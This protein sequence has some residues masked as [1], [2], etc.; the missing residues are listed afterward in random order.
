MH[1]WAIAKDGDRKSY[2]A[3]SL[4][5]T[6]MKGKDE[7]GDTA[8]EITV[9]SMDGR[10]GRVIGQPWSDDTIQADFGVGKID[11]RNDTSE[12]VFSTY[13]GG[14]HC[15]T[16]TKI[17]ELTKSGWVVLDLGPHDGDT[18]L[19]PADV[20]GTSTRAFVLYDDRFLY[21]FAS[22][23]DSY[24]P[25]QVFVIRDA[26][27]VDESA[28]G[29]FRAVYGKDL[30]ETEAGCRKHQNGACAGFV[31]DATRLGRFD[32]AWATMLQNYNKTD[33]WQLPTDCDVE[34][35][36]TGECPKG[37]EHKFGNYPDALRAFLKRNGYIAEGGR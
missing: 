11:P 10:V 7:D 12:V 30:K 19:F 9:K 22:H 14:A 20:N 34:L 33:D 18:P 24:S 26:K 27:L 36:K 29:K 6:L 15:C 1:S 3:A 32:E 13:S 4:V 5:V 23:A 8:P 16:D 35:G 21:A 37:H 25:P 17:L 2:S 31:A 28:S